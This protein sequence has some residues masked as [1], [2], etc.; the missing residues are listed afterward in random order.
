MSG[1][2]G[3]ASEESGASARRQNRR[4]RRR[5]FVDYCSFGLYSTRMTFRPPE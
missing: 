1:T 4:L 3:T 5:G 2:G